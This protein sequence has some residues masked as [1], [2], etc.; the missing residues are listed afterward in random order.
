PLGPR[1]SPA[2]SFV[3]GSAGRRAAAPGSPFAAQA[4]GPF[5]SEFSPA[6]P[7]HLY[8]SNAHGGAGNGSVSALAVAGNG[9]ITSIGTSPYPDGQTAPCWVEISHDGSYLF[10]VNTGSTSISSYH[11]KA[12]GSLNYFTLTAFKR[13][14]GIRPFAGRLDPLPTWLYVVDAALAA[15]R[16]FP[17]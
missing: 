17:F 12:D 6:D 1:A 13:G 11:I 7:T 9:A 5:G 3:G 16:V 8:V 10:T 15:A 2:G 14:V 4:A